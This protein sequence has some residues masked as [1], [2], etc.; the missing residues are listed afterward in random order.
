M[1]KARTDGLLLL[2]LG[3]VLFVV[4]GIVLEASSPATMGDFRMHYFPARCTLQHGDPYNEGDVLRTYRAE[5]SGLPEEPLGARLMTTEYIYPPT[6]LTFTV[7]LALLPYSRARLVWMAISFVGLIVAGYLTW[8]LAAVYAPEVSG[9]LIGFLLANSEL[10]VTNGNV[11]GIAISLSAIA[12][13]CFVKER[14][15]ALGVLC[16]AAS[17]MLKPHDTWL[18]WL[19][20]LLAGEA[21]RKRALQAMGAWLV[22]SLPAVAWVTHIAPH[23]LHELRSN[24]D[25]IS[26]RGGT[27]PS[28]GTLGPPLIIDLQAAVSF[29]RND[30]RVENLLSYCIC[31]VILLVWCA[32][33][34]RARPSLGNAWLGLAS[35][36][37]LAMLPV[38]HR[39]IDAKVLLLTIPACA[40]LR[41]QGGRVGRIAVAL[42]V[43]GLFVTADIPWVID[44]GVLRH[45]GPPDTGLLGKLLV[46]SQIVLVPLVL[47]TEGVFFLWVYAARLREQGIAA[48]V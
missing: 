20:F 42:T 44:V 15:V 26:A 11:A 14:C 18:V 31:G 41:C 38:Y 30:P 4:F 13:W 39:E 47:L 10:V 36:A 28:F 34:V 29:F 48:A 8:D 21:Y 24:L 6:T 27:D 22:L 35:V 9:A 33:T 16:M 45:F 5:R 3:S 2:S 1:T 32:V 46:A 12:V 7:P 40:M 17:L 37:A 23:W 43:A 19:Y 25:A